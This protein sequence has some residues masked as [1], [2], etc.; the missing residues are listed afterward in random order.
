M[1]PAEVCVADGILRCVIRFTALSVSASVRGL[2]PPLWQKL[3]FF[4]NVTN[5]LDRERPQTPAVIGTGGTGQPNPALYD[6]I[7]RTYTVGF[8]ILF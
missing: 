7:G 6:T 4:G 2:S 3:R 1:P 5:L 8:N